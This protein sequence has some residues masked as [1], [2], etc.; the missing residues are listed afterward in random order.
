MKHARCSQK[1]CAKW[2]ELWSIILQ[3][4]QCSTWWMETS[5]MH[6]YTMNTCRLCWQYLAEANEACIG[7]RWAIYTEPTS[8][9]HCE[10]SGLQVL[11]THF[12]REKETKYHICGVS[13]TS[14]VF[15]IP[16]NQEKCV[17]SLMWMDSI[18]YRPHWRPILCGAEGPR[19]LLSLS[20][21]RGRLASW[22]RNSL[23]Y[24]VKSLRL[25]FMDTIFIR[26]TFD[27]ILLF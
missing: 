16:W 26:I 15:A 18:A 8:P 25:Q 3:N 24:F 13:N 2:G 4:K 1:L 9:V 14:Y 10:P 6:W 5:R 22:E 12:K 21:L 23:T 20:S 19:P 17:N 27:G 7:E 11:V